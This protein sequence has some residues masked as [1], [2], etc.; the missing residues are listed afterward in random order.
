MSVRPITVGEES[1]ATGHPFVNIFAL[2]GGT[3]GLLLYL[4]RSRIP[5]TQNWFA[6]PGHLLKFGLLVGGGYLIGGA[7]AMGFFTDRELLRLAR[8]HRQDKALNV[9]GF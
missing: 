7:V 1:K 8:R 9:E 3:Q 4:H 5:I 2:F 6:P